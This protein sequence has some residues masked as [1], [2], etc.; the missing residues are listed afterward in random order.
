MRMP[1]RNTS[2]RGISSITRE[3]PTASKD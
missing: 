3:P 2:V 1:P